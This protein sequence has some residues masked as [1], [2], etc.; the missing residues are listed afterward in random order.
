MKSKQTL[1]ING[2]HL[3][4]ESVGIIL[5]SIWIKDD[6]SELIIKSP[7]FGNKGELHFRPLKE[8]EINL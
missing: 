5:D 7:F 2:F 8:G 6:G 4:K 3:V 1:K